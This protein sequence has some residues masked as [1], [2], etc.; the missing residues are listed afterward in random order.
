[1]KFNAKKISANLLDKQSGESYWKD[2]STAKVG[3]IELDDHALSVVASRL[4]LEVDCV[5]KDIYNFVNGSYREK[6]QAPGGSRVGDF[7]ESIALLLALELC[8]RGELTQVVRVVSYRMVGKKAKKGER[9]YPI[10]DFLIRK[11]LAVGCL[12]VKTTTVP[13]Y[14]RLSMAKRNVQ[15]AQCLSVESLRLKTLRQLAYSKDGNPVTMKHQVQVI[16]ETFCPFPS[17]FG[18]GVAVSILDGRMMWLRQ[19]RKLRTPAP[20]S[21]FGRNCW[22]CMDS[23]NGPVDMSVA[24]MHNSPGILKMVGSRGFGKLFMPA[25]SRWE[26]SLWCRHEGLVSEFSVILRRVLYGWVQELGLPPDA[27]EA[28]LGS[29]IDHIHGAAAQYGL[30]GG[31]NPSDF[32]DVRRLDLQ[33]EPAFEMVDIRKIPS[34][35]ESLLEA[36]ETSGR[37]CAEHEISHLGVAVVLTV[38]AT[39]VDVRWCGS[40][41][42]RGT[43]VDSHG[44][45][46]KVV[47]ELMNVLWEGTGPF[48]NMEEIVATVFGSSVRLGWRVTENDQNWTGFDRSMPRWFHWLA[49]GDSRAILRV[50]TDGRAQLTIR[51][52]S[53][54]N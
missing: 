14:H 9:E 16:D 42:R 12:E 17:D 22:N 24:W 48:W 23:S 19:E 28:F 13:D 32:R 30:N 10:P 11:D 37:F 39:V 40:H 52:V 21:K 26:Q 25:Y 27:R 5:A 3:F 51:R 8:D 33:S 7:G 29:W 2:Y 47:A 38:S 6:T 4:E 44:E 20:C 34:I 1:M 43:V 45:A 54:P 53:G 49:L 41:W 46:K 18:I 15:I 35:L 31:F 36:D 50:F